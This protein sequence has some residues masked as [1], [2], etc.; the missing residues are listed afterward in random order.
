[1]FEHLR[2][3]WVNWHQMVGM[4]V[5]IRKEIKSSIHKT[6][7]SCTEWVKMK[8]DFCKKMWCQGS[9]ALLQCFWTYCSQTVTTQLPAQLLA[10]HV[11]QPKWKVCLTLLSLESNVFYLRKSRPNPIKTL[12]FDLAQDL[13]GMNS[14]FVTIG[15]NFF[16]N[17]IC[18]C[19]CA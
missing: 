5:G 6:Y 4:G 17:F 15:N 18:I 11:N 19:L 1:M 3:I 14:V 12:N 10:L 16:L 13:A 7:P 8:A 9:F 2:M